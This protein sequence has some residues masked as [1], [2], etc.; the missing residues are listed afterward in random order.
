MVRARGSG[1]ERRSSLPPT[2]K[3]RVTWQPT[4]QI[5]LGVTKKT[6]EQSEAK[7]RGGTVNAD[8]GRHTRPTRAESER[9]RDG[10]VHDDGQPTRRTRTN[11]APLIRRTTTTTTSTSTASRGRRKGQLSCTIQRDPLHIRSALVFWR[12]SRSKWW[13]ITATAARW[14]TPRLARSRTKLCGA[15]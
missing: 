7:G 2:S 3:R 1:R 9:E 12:E 4:R 6:A 14:H 8:G 5:F 13:R 11:Q 15:R 10:T